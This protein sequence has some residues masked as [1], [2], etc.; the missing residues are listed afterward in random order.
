VTTRQAEV[1]VNLANSRMSARAAARRMFVHPQ[2]IY[3]NIKQIRKK[4]GLDPTNF[5]D[6]CRLLPAAESVL[7]GE[8]E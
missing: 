3:Y 4:T 1:I 2:T 8:A 7:K 6:L 5:H